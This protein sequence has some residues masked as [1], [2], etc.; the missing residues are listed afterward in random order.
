MK[1]KDI[2]LSFEERAKDLLSRLTI[3]EKISQMLYNSS[4]IEHL[5][6]PE[7]N[8]WN[9]CLHGV[10]RNGTATVFPQAIALAATWDTSLINNVADVISTEARAKHH[11]SARKG[12][13]GIYKG[14]NFW[15]PNINIFRDPR[16]GRG[17]ETYGEDPY[18][19]AKIAVAFIK[20]IQGNHHKYLK[21]AATAKH[22]AV[23]SGPEPK[24]HSFNAV[25][26]KKDLYETYLP[27]FKEC[28]QEAS[29][30]SVMGA[31]NRTN[32]E[33][34]CASRTLLNDILRNEWGFKG[35][36]VSDC[37]AVCDIHLHHKCTKNAQESAALAV[38]N[39]CD[40]NCGVTYEYLISAYEERLITEEEIDAALFRILISR[41]KL[42]LFDPPEKVHYSSI[43]YEL[44]DAPEHRKLALETAQ[45]SI[46]LLKN[47]NN[48]LPLKKNLKSIAV[49]GPNANDRDVL[50]GNYNGIP[51]KYVTPLEGIRNK[52]SSEARV[53]YAQGC[54]LNEKVEGAQFGKFERGFAEAAVI[55]ERA[56]AVV[57]VMG[58]SSYYEGE[59]G[60]AADSAA[61][62]DRSHI[63]L[64]GLQHKLI[65]YI[66][67]TGKPI[68]L[69][70]LSGSPVAINWENDNLDAVIEAWYPGEE[71]G[72]AVA[73]V[74]F[75][76]YNPAGRLPVTF[77]KSLDQIPDF[78]DYNMN[79][80]KGR[81]YKYMKAEP[82]YP[83]GYGLSYTNFEYSEIKLSSDKIKS[84]DSLDV[85][86]DIK[87]TGNYDGDEVIQLYLSYP[88]E[89]KN[90]PF[91][92]L[93]GF[94]RIYLKINQKEKILFKLSP[95]DF[96][97]V[98]EDGKNII[99]PGKYKISVGGS[100]PDKC[101]E[102]LT[103]RKTK[104]KE[105]EIIN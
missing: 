94:K 58:L 75:G 35:H 69:V 84:D 25:V 44:N 99:Y 17:Q 26:G 29:V 70:I 31:Y 5:D 90:L 14:L 45:K 50:L 48:I 79:S 47:K 23:H 95:A 53:F 33:P 97:S 6:I 52:L 37:G 1:F 60:D 4:A 56:E 93:R 38:K 96:S 80:N 104:I 105:F 34:C 103:G 102:L 71:G 20:G 89:I 85:E 82:L 27:A 64:P 68:I 81:T 98:D 73:D 65:E 78:D 22:F 10:A 51:S 24:R 21:A 11:E 101:S 41:F 63:N 61:G 19:T 36:V 7:Y 30:E 88:S 62:G 49:I 66:S 18:L 9:E 16:W 12:D 2:S 46:V 92:Q 67:S 43:P 83:F 74:I 28:V 100:Q 3:K 39:G 57:M 40:L 86:F 8:W 32:G 77:P 42:G 59:E 54:L 13:R 76:D 72:N 87:N 91:R 15:T 55:A